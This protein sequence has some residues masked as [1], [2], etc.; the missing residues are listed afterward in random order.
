MIQGHG[1]DDEAAPQC[2][3]S[4]SR[5]AGNRQA[6]RASIQNT[7]VCARRDD[8]PAERGRYTDALG[9]RCSFLI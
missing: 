8:E 3:Q 2:P 9:A 6:K 1:A 7:A 4:V 5:D